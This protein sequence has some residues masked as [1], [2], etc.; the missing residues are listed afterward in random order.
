VIVNGIV[1]AEDGRKMSKRLQNYPDPMD[2][3]E[4][5]S[6]D[7]LR[8]YL[9]S[10]PVLAGE[11]LNFSE[12]GVKDVFRKIS[13]LVWNVYKFFAM[14]QNTKNPNKERPSSPHILDK[15]ILARLDELTAEVTK[16]MEAYHLPKAV[17]PF[18]KF[19]SDLSTWYLRRSRDRFKSEDAVDKHAALSITGYVLEELAKLMAPFMPFLAEELWQGVSG[20]GYAEAERSV[21]LED[22]PAA[23]GADKKTLDDMSLVR[24]VVELGLAK[25]DEAGIK[26]RQ[27][28]ASMTVRGVGSEL[29][30]GMW[31]LVK[32]EVNV[33]Q[34]KPKAGYGKLEVELDIQLTP[35]LKAEGV[36]RELVRFINALRKQAGLTIEDRASVYWQSDSQEVVKAIESYGRDIRLDTLSD[37]IKPGQAPSRPEAEKEVKVDGENV[38]LQIIKSD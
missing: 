24:Q 30:A 7:A 12:D 27:P 14:Y 6:V 37:H 13:M 22:W 11:N 2:V 5:Y 9:L 10:S 1:L 19:I 32:D 3:A 34:I 18:E 25:R 35:E 15:W 28:L 4:A 23:R 20:L 36:K 31:Q 29:E 8:Y 17:R 16:H 21:H 33:K 26:V 38:T